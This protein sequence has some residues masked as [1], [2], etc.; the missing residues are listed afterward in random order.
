[1]SSL[2]K[3][4]EQ[5]FGK[6]N[7][8]LRDMYKAYDLEN[9]SLHGYDVVDGKAYWDALESKR[10]YDSELLLEKN[11]ANPD[12]EPDTSTPYNQEGSGA[13]F[14]DLIEKMPYL[15]QIEKEIIQLLW[16]GRTQEEIAVVLNMKRVTVATH[17]DR[18]RKKITRNGVNKNG[19]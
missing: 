15:N 16:E 12:V 10:H 3:D 4:L 19:F 9:N 5:K 13:E 17:L 14:D 18:A 7:K 2:D 11:R 8:K 1:M 6:S